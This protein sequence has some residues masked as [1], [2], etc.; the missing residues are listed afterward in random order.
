MDRQQGADRQRGVDLRS[1]FDAPTEIYPDPGSLAKIPDMEGYA[2]EKTF[3]DDSDFE[4]MGWHD[5]T[6]W[7]M[8][9]HAERFEFLLDLD[10]IF[11]WVKPGEGET[12]FQFWVSP[13]TLIVENAHDIAIEVRS[14]KGMLEISDLHRG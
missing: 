13:V 14:S 5:C 4:T 9:E 6:I 7:S 1:C 11:G 10:Y 12:Y 8:H 3:W 2:L